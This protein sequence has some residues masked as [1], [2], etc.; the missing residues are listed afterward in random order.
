MSRLLLVRHGDTELNSRERF[1]GCTDV[2]LSTQ[3][4]RQAER[5]R[6][7]LASEKIDAVYASDL[8]RAWRTAEIIATVHQI[9]VMTCPEIRETN[10]GKIEGLSFEEVSRL[11]PDLTESWLSW[12]VQMRFPDG[13]GVC[14][15]DAR[16]RKFKDRLGKHALEETILI[17]AHAGTLRML[18]CQLLGLEIHYWRQL[19]VGLAS[20]SI[21][22]T[23]QGADILTLLNDLSHLK[24]DS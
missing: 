14:E 18:I 11:Y 3:G 24:G 7:R 16:V 15:V 9:E 10:F 13:E 1:W 4:I 19:R 17:V 2:K 23:Y 5:M 20:L 21:V 8:E 22:E 6:E 12:D